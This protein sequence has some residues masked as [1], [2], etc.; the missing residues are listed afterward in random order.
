M[1]NM[2]LLKEISLVLF[3]T[4]IAFALS[5]NRNLQIEI[6]RGGHLTASFAF[7]TFHMVHSTLAHAQT[8]YHVSQFGH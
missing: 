1:T 6:E 7:R 5:L 8:N 4:N 3:V 2:T